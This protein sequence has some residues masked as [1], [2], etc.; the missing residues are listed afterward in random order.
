MAT[1]DEQRKR[2]SSRTVNKNRA[3]KLSNRLEKWALAKKSHANYEDMEMT[4]SQVTA[5]KIL[6]SKIQPDLKAVEKTDVTDYGDD[7]HAV[8]A[9]ALD[10]FITDRFSEIPPVQEVSKGK[11]N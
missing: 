5:A 6:L 7:P 8:T 2:F 11:P 9:E 3:T 4:Q 1:R 10:R